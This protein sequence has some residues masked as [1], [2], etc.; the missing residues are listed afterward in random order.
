LTPLTQDE[1]VWLAKNPDH[2]KAKAIA[3]AIMQSK[4]N[5][6][7]FESHVQLQ[8]AINVFRRAIRNG[9]IQLDIKS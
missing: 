2:P 3:E 4:R 7:A 1:Q 8:N 5:P 9:E 6:T